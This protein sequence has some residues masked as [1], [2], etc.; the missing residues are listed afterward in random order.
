[1]KIKWDK[2]PATTGQ[3]NL[4]DYLI[5][6]AELFPT[7]AVIIIMIIE[8]ITIPFFFI[9]WKTYAKGAECYA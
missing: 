7:S 9:M 6:L 2:T 1:M 4:A 3:K 8:I 5:S